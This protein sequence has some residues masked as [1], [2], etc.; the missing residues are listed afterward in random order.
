MMSLVFHAYSKVL[1]LVTVVLVSHRAMQLGGY[2]WHK[3]LYV[4]VDINNNMSVFAWKK[5]IVIL[6]EKML[7]ITCML[8]S[9]M[10]LG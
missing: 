2:H 6:N 3:L 5:Y 8:F 10:T 9:M 1:V 7:Q 4:P